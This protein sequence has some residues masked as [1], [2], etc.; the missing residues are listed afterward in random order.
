MAREELRRAL[1]TGQRVPD[2]VREGEQELVLQLL[3]GADEVGQ[4]HSHRAVERV[5]QQELRGEQVAGRR[6]IRQ[7]FPQRPP[8]LL[9]QEAE[10]ENDVGRLQ[11]LTAAR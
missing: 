9:P 11:A 3:D 5:V 10:F 7:L 8:D 1:E 6:A 2:V 4:A